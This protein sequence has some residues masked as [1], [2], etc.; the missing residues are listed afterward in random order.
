[1]A[2][3]GFY[4]L[5]VLYNL[6]RG[7]VGV[8]PNRSHPPPMSTTS[9]SGSRSP[10]AESGQPYSPLSSTTQFG[11][12]T[13]KRKPN[14][15]RPV[16][17]PTPIALGTSVLQKLQLD[18]DE[19]QTYD[20][21]KYEQFI[22]QDFQRHRVF[23]GID[24]FMTHVLPVPEN[25]KALW[26]RT[27][28]QIKRDATFSTARWDYYRQCATRGVKESNFYGPLVD[29]GNAI[30]DVSKN[31]NTVSV[32]PQTPQL[33][34]RNDPKKVLCGVMTDLSPDIVAVHDGFLPHIRSGERD[35][36]RLEQSNLTWAQPLQA[37]EVKPW[38]GALIDGSCMPR[39]K[40]N[41]TPATT[42]RDVLS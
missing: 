39:L 4:Q 15:T 34:L 29:M 24:V 23:V 28:R 35:G 19:D 21:D 37:L 26:G 36:R 42:S 25:W 41:G 27:I 20:I 33:Y 30:L 9:S 17:D 18:T 12:K 8:P 40:V 13:P 38:D 14:A 6:S 2:L 10:T 5:A 31:S 32:R 7:D 22:T 3:V 11:L 16:P 1:M